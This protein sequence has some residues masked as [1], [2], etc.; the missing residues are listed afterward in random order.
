MWKEEN[1]GTPVNEAPQAPEN[2]E[3]P[4]PPSTISPWGN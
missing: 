2:P 1:G 3:N 4:L